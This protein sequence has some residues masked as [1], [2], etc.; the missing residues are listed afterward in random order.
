MKSATTVSQ[1]VNQPINQSE[2]VSARPTLSRAANPVKLKIGRFGGSKIRRNSK[3]FRD[4]QRHTE[5]NLF[6]YID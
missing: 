2:L 1:L 6:Y 5:N 4:I 3:H